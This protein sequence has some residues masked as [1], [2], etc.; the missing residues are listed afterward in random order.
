MNKEICPACEQLNTSCMCFYPNDG[1]TEANRL[2]QDSLRSYIK[3]ERAFFADR[4][5]KME[6]V[7][8]DNSVVRS[9][10]TRGV[11]RP[12]WNSYEVVKD[13]LEW[14]PLGGDLEGRLG[15][16]GLMELRIHGGCGTELFISEE[17]LRNAIAMYDADDRPTLGSGRE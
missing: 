12:C 15:E 1:I 14:T 6:C 5:D 8:C 7:A 16:D 10:L 17:A 4:K 11:C 13:L 2:A 9:S 3:G